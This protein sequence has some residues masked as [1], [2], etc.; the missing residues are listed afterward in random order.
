MRKR[1]KKLKKEAIMETELE[2]G[3]MDR[4]RTAHGLCEMNC[5]LKE[6]N[7]C[8]LVRPRIRGECLNGV[9]PCPWVSCR[10]H[11]LWDHNSVLMRYRSHQ[12]DEDELVEILFRMPETCALDVAD[13]G[14]ATLQEIADILKMTRERVRQISIA[15]YEEHADPPPPPPPQA[16]GSDNDDK[17][18]K[19]P[20]RSAIQKITGWRKEALREFADW[21]PVRRCSVI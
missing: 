10:Y 18:K 19:T 21:C 3:C 14:G 20:P 2:Y 7:R 6:N 11:L 4:A 5:N 1:P 17:K 13:G 9:R 8:I 12:I 15:R 16:D